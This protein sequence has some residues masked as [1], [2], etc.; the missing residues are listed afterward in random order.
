MYRAQRTLA[1]PPRAAVVLIRREARQGGDRL[2]VEPPQFGHQRGAGHLAHPVDA[3]DD[4]GRTAPVVMRLDELQDHSIDVP[5]LL[6]DGVEY[7]NDALLRRLR[8]RMI[9]LDLKLLDASR[10]AIAGD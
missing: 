10:P 6:A 9:V 7:A 5:E 1:R 3:L 8:G 2:A 4:F